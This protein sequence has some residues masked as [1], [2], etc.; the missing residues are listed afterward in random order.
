MNAN[1]KSRALAR[2]KLREPVAEVLRANGASQ[3][4]NNRQQAQNWVHVAA[5]LDMSQGRR[6][7]AGRTIP[8]LVLGASCAFVA[9]F[10]VAQFRFRDPIADVLTIPSA[11]IDIV[12]SQPSSSA[13][14]PDLRLAGGA[15]FERLTGPEPTASGKPRLVTF[16]DGSTLTAVTTDT[17]VEPLAMTERDVTLRLVSGVVDVSV[18][19]G[20]GRKWTI[21]AGEL[22][23]EVVGTQFTVSRTFQ[24]SAVTVKEGVVLVRSPK[25]TDGAQRLS[26]GNSVQFALHEPNT[27]TAAASLEALQ[28]KAD[29]ARQAGDLR[30]ASAHLQRLLRS[31]PKDARTGVAAFQLALVTQQLGA[32]VTQVVAAFETALTKAHGQSLRQ[33]CYWRL[34]LALEHA[35][36]TQ[37]ARERAEQSLSAYPKGR[38]AGELKR[39]IHELPTGPAAAP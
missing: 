26:A 35:G 38:Y 11:R 13:Q 28:D 10:V 15:E 14:T 29:A 12:S 20:G 39:R 32:P 30:A 36:Q 31:F 2:L 23:V 24:Q 25:L 27:E 3:L 5:R 22:S 21:E 1:Q 18:A 33:D 37:R 7:R 34:V 4:E 19:K 6:S 9:L 17:L 16:E 8:L